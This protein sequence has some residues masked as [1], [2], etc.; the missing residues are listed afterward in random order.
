MMTAEIVISN[1]HTTIAPF[2]SAIRLVKRIAASVPVRTGENPS[3]SA[4]SSPNYSKRTF[5]IETTE[6]SKKTTADGIVTIRRENTDL[7][8]E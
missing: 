6:F 5:L 7:E 1:T 4:G 2:P 8:K 3:K